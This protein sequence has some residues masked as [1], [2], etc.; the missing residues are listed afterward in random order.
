MIG[1]NAVITFHRRKNPGASVSQVFLLAAVFWFVWIFSTAELLLVRYPLRGVAQAVLDWWY[2]NNLRLVWLSLLGLGAAFHFVP[3]LTGR[4]LQG[5][6]LALLAFWGLTLVGSWCGIPNSAPLPAWLPTL[7]TVAAVLLVI[8]VL[9]AG[10][11]LYRTAGGIRMAGQAPELRFF[12]AGLCAFFLAAL[13]CIAGA[14]PPFGNITDFTW[15]TAA[16]G[17]L[18]I[19]GFLGLIFFGAAYHIMPQVVGAGWPFPKLVRLHFWFAASGVVVLVLPEA[20]GGIVQGFALNNPSIPFADVVKGTL[21]FLRPATSGDLLI[22]IGHIFFLTN[23]A[24]LARSYYR[25]RAIAA[26][27]KVTEDRFAAGAKA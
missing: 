22:A 16:R 27:D 9:A 17:H 19:N 24:G 23:L 21:G 25:P 5:R 26:W 18:Q 3:K 1:L 11:S 7:S 15:F 2:S 6:P 13:M 4:E 14:L 8:P 12:Y 20:V 10:L